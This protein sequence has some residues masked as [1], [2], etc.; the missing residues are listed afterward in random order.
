MQND[1]TLVAINKRT[2]QPEVQFKK[3]NLTKIVTS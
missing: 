3:F 2:N 1:F